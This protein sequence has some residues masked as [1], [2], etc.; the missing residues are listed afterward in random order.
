MENV[1]TTPIIIEFN[2]L[3]GSGKTTI[4]HALREKFESM[5]ITTCFGYF[6][7]RFFSDARFLYLM[8]YYWGKLRI[9]YNYSRLLPRRP[10]MSWILSMINIIRMYKQFIADHPKDVMLIDHGVVQSMISIAHQYPI[11]T[12]ELKPLLESIGLSEF[13]LV[14]VNTQIEIEASNKRIE[15]RPSNGCRVES[16]SE[17]ERRRIL[18]I[19]NA[20]FKEV[21]NAIK[22]ISDYSYV[23]DVNTDRP[24]D[25]SVEIILSKMS[26]IYPSISCALSR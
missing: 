16:M 14:I 9:V 3:P 8:P 7:Y 19:Q 10:S 26:K 11:V 20:N 13:P 5:G 17:K 2:G 23:I 24:I 15:E 22:E 12:N 4:V 6:R 18:T 1:F 21:R 25:D